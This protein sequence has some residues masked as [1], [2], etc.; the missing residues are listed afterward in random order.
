[1][2]KLEL[3]ITP[4]LMERIDEVVGL[5]GYNSREELVR[6]IILRFLD[7]HTLKMKSC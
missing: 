1:M 3:S 7:G 6:C 4:Q 2:E 5:L